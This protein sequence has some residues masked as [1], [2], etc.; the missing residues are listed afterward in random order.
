M[1]EQLEERLTLCKYGWPD[2][3]CDMDLAGHISAL[4]HYLFLD[5]SWSLIDIKF[6]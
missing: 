3:R 2:P 5:S 1:L 6:K 4:T